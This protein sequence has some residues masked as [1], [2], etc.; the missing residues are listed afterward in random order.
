MKLENEVEQRERE[1]EGQREDKVA[2][3][4]VGVWGEG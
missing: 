1:N 4:G 2:G 3:D